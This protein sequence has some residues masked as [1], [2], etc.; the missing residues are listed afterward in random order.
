M[1]RKT[2]PTEPLLESRQTSDEFDTML[3]LGIIDGEYSITKLAVDLF[4]RRYNSNPNSFS[5]LVEDRYV[6]FTGQASHENVAYTVVGRQ[7][8]NGGKAK[9]T[10]TITDNSNSYHNSSFKNLH[11]DVPLK[12]PEVNRMVIAMQV[13]DM[14]DYLN[15]RYRKN[16]NEANQ[17][18]M[19]PEEELLTMISLGLFEP[20]P[21]VNVIDIANVVAEGLNGK[22]EGYAIYDD[23]VTAT[24]NFTLDGEAL[25]FGVNVFEDHQL[26]EIAVG[27]SGWTNPNDFDFDSLNYTKRTFPG[28]ADVLE[29]ARKLT[30]NYVSSRRN[31]TVNERLSGNTEE[32][33]NADPREVLTLIDLGMIETANGK[34]SA[35]VAETVLERYGKHMKQGLNFWQGDVYFE[36]YVS[37]TH[38]MDLWQESSNDRIR[39][40]VGYY[41]DRSSPVRTTDSESV[42]IKKGEVVPNEEARRI[43]DVIV[44]KLER[45]I[46]RGTAINENEHQEVSVPFED[47]AVMAE[48][49]IYDVN[50]V[51]LINVG[52]LLIENYGIVDP[53]MK[54]VLG[55]VKL[56]FRIKTKRGND[57][58]VR[59]SLT[60]KDAAMMINVEQLFRHSSNNT[61]RKIERIDYDDPEQSAIRIANKAVEIINEVDARA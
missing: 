20:D 14:F 31:G 44:Q 6:S 4:V 51:N 42:V 26:L 32:F 33:N 57:L 19:M 1:S 54:I 9:L 58:V 48:I 27:K 40:T 16:V 13:E 17:F 39:F 61:A 24:V 30:R 15:A 10:L 2:K 60:D 43:A 21:N 38:L 28:P 53:Q 55:T 23:N 18:P 22:V 35:Y 47:F 49:G 25:D 8:R 34:I 36:A 56:I 59:L 29:M 3:D 5:F 52:R 37:E 12:N 50:F 11:F 7:E 45:I 46:S 41:E